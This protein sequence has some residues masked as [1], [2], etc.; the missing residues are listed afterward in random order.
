MRR[1]V[2][3]TPPSD[4]VERRVLD[5][6]DDAHRQLRFR[7][8]EPR[9]WIGSLRRMTFARAVQGS[10]GIEGYNASLDDVL[11]AVEGGPML[12]ADTDTQL[13][14]TGYRDAMTYVLQVAQDPVPPTIG[15]G[16][17]KALHFM[18]IK[19]EP[20]KSPG[21]WRPGTIYVRNDAT[22]EIAYESPGHELVPALVNATIREL[23]DSEAPVLVR[24]AMAHLNLVMI[25]PFS[26]GNGRM[27][28]ALQ[29]LVL[30]REQVVAPVFSS[31]EEYLGRNIQA[32]YDVLAEV[33]QGSWNP[34]RDARPWIRVCLTAHYHQAMTHLRRI[35][36]AERLWAACAELALD[37]GL[38]ERAASGLYDAAHGMRIRN[39]F[40]RKLVQETLGEQ[41]SELTAT[42]DLKAMVDAGLLDPVGERRGRHYVARESVIDLRRGIRENRPARDT[43]DPFVLASQQ[44]QMKLG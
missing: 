31:V 20:Q 24:A 9:R 19:H 3:Q 28:R 18:M 5:L 8:G 37:H 17:L 10:N 16:L 30:A 6:I 36:E 2:F 35:E 29:T 27:A 21:R 26:D 43:T 40:Y 42:R 1:V 25:H 12:D 22:G 39:A 34:Q 7:V 4:A 15:E 14:L 11:A 44:L 33:G 32:Y 23:E 38:L 13:A 41:I